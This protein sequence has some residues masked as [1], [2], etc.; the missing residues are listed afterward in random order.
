MVSSGLVIITTGALQAG[1]HSRYLGLSIP[2]G[3]PGRLLPH[4]PFFSLKSMVIIGQVEEV[5][6][7]TEASG[8][9]SVCE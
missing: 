6:L 7:S 8:W 9:C 2:F 5:L 3:T 1:S 4:A